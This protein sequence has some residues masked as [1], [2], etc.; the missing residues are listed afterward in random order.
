[1]VTTHVMDA[2]RGIPAFRMPIQLDVLITGYGWREIGHGLTNAEGR[3]HDFGEPEAPGVYRL[4]FDV[5]SYSPDA[6]FP[7]ITVTFEIKD[8]AERFHIPLIISPFGY[9]THR[10]P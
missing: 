5:A 3:V 9:S 2:A 10:E 7:S 4:M 1:M 6:F 8:P